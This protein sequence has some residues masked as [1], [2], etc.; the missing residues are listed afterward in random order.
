MAREPEDLHGERHEAPN[1]G[2]VRIKTRLADALRIDA[3]A[4]PPLHVAREPIHFLEIKSQ[5][6]THI[7]KSAARPI[8]DDG[9]REGR[10][11]TAI[12][13]VNMLNDFFAPF[14]LEIH[15]DI[16]RLIALLEMKRSN[17]IAMRKGSTSVIFRQ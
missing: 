11:L 10:A 4:I 14:M 17:S 9:G 13:P 12:F 3:R 2:V 7:A 15:V 8:G 1:P 16:R 6:L 5:G